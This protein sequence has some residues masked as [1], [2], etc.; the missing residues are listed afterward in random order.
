MT[1]P[2]DLNILAWYVDAIMQ[3][4][5][6]YC[7][8]QVKPK[9]DHDS[10]K[11]NGGT[12]ITTYISGLPDGVMSHIDHDSYEEAEARLREYFNGDPLDMYE[13]LRRKKI[14][15]INQQIEYLQEQLDELEGDKL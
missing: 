8:V 6:T 12:K 10:H 13:E 1:E 15:V 11:Y 4:H 2:N 14:A 7:T 3:K 5:G 9:F